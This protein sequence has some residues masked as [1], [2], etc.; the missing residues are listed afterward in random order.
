MLTTPRGLEVN[1]KVRLITLTFFPTI[2]RSTA[3]LEARVQLG[4]RA[5]ILTRI[6][7]TLGFL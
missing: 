2:P 3:T 1:K 5:S 6:I 7:S 4:T